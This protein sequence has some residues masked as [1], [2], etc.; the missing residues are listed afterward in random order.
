MNTRDTA[1]NPYP[2]DSTTH[3]CCQGIGSHTQNCPQSSTEPPPCGF[4]WCHNDKPEHVEHYG[5][6]STTGSYSGP[7]TFS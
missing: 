6:G 4:H 5:N 2:V 7:G 3:P 1:T